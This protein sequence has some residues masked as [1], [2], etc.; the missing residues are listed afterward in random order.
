LGLPRKFGSSCYLRNTRF[1]VKKQNPP[2]ALFASNQDEK[3]AYEDTCRIEFGEYQTLAEELQETNDVS[4]GNVRLDSLES[5]VLVATLTTASSFGNV[6]NL[7]ISDVDITSIVLGDMTLITSTLSAVLGMYSVLNFSS[8]ILYGKTLLSIG[9]DDT[10]DKFLQ[11]TEKERNRGISAFQGSLALFMCELV[12]V[13]VS[14]VRADEQLPCLVAL[15][16]MSSF[17][18]NDWKT[19]NDKA[20]P[21]YSDEIQEERN[22]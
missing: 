3:S 8:C 17:I 4:R 16:V 20:M 1:Q 19:I 22:F 6:L 14:K 5:Y 18:L 2:R 13:A 10:C 9:S 7:G 15:L 12:E 11:A 21:I